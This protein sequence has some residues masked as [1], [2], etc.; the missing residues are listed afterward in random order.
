MAKKKERLLS[1]HMSIKYFLVFTTFHTLPVGTVYILV[2]VTNRRI[3]QKNMIQNYC[4]LQVLQHFFY[5]YLNQKIKKR[6]KQ[7]RFYIP[8][9]YMKLILINFWINIWTF[10]QKEKLF[11]HVV[12]FLIYTIFLFFFLEKSTPFSNARNKIPI[13]EFFFL[14]FIPFFNFFFF[15]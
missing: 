10:L 5:Y 8:W 4:Y 1:C 6:T 2:I 14:F 15:C 13:R 3:I 9:E 11:S 12:F 7:T